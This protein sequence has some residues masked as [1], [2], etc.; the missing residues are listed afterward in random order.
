MKAKHV[1]LTMGLSLVMGLGVAA[2]MSA[3]REVK[4]ANAVAQTC[5]FDV[6][7]QANLMQGNERYATY[8]F[9]NTSN[10]WVSMTGV[11]GNIY[12]FSADPAT[13]DHIILCRMNKAAT[14]NKWENKWDQTGNL[15]FTTSTK[16]FRAT[17]QSSDG[18]FSAEAYT[19][20]YGLVGDK[21]G[22]TSD[23]D[24]VIDGV[25]ATLTKVMDA[26]DKVKVRANHA[27]TVS[28]GY[29]S[30][31]STSK[32][33]FT[34]DGENMQANE[35]GA[36]TFD[37]NFATGTLNVTF[38][39]ATVSV[40]IYKNDTATKYETQNVALGGLPEAPAYVY[41]ESFDG[42]WYTDAAMETECTGVTASTTKLYCK[43]TVAA[44]VTFTLDKTRATDKFA[45]TYLYTWFEGH[46]PKTAWPG[47][48]FTTSTF[49]VK[50]GS[51]FII[52]AGQGKEQTVDVTPST[53]ANDTLRILNSTDGEGHYNVKWASEVDS[54]KYSI[55]GGT[56][57]S[58]QEEDDEQFASLTTVEL[59]KGD[60]ITFTKNGAPYA[61]TPKDDDQFTNVYLNGDDELVA[62]RDCNEKFYLNVVTNKLWN[63][64]FPSGFY[65]L[66]DNNGWN[67][68]TG[69]AASQ[70]GESDTY[71]VENVPL[72]AGQGIKMTYVDSDAK[73]VTYYN[74]DASKVISSTGVAYSVDDTNHNLIATNGGTYNIY[75]NTTST[76]YSIEDTVAPTYKVSVNGVAK[77]LPTHEGTE[78][79]TA[80]LTLTAGQEIKVLRN[81]VVDTS[82]T[83]KQSRN[84]NVRSDGTVLVD[85]TNAHIYV[86]TS[87]KTIFVEGVPFGG[88]H[89]IRNDHELITMTHGSEY[90][91]YDQYYSDMVNFS[92]NDK[93]KFV[94]T[95]DQYD[96]H[97]T[98]IPGLPDEF[99]IGTINPG[100]NG[101]KFAVDGEYIKCITAIQTKVYLKLKYHQDEVYFGTVEQ[102]ITD[103]ITF[104]QNFC[105]AIEDVCED[106]ESAK[107]TEELATARTALENAWAAQVTAFNGLS[108]EA[109]NYLKS[110]A[111]HSVHELDEFFAKYDRVYTYRGIRF[112]WTLFNFLEVNYN[113]SAYINPI[114]INKT[115]S[116]VMVSIIASMVTLFASA[117]VVLFLFKKK[118]HN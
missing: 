52:N 51:K 24:M 110:Q 105:T 87:D 109:R 10:G 12:S 15:D 36:Y 88:Y 58:L 17:S 113:N 91:G 96:E 21:I 8:Y 75:Y 6:N 116:V 64:E 78:Y 22:W 84:N 67:V 47:D 56:E 9:N 1:F 79:S 57:I 104:G 85:A 25:H 76:Y 80:A 5:Y 28:Y 34:A 71:Y 60:V 74:A 37:L 59:H 106:V 30:L 97:E 100:D 39:D 63:G 7:G 44:D 101:P 14:E 65:L 29:N 16:Y 108:E 70:E 90:E 69:L 20:V 50:A 46:D 102:Y 26:G 2:G 23:I 86:D 43:T 55:N 99:S 27:W 95:N 77:E 61:V 3:N 92:V 103:A 115:N 68:K 35:S 33:L 4:A 107:T 13:Y 111:A 81:D 53:V 118:K 82:F 114:M 31:D 48:K 73:N 66:G 42:K 89:I 54:Y 32:A 49:T 83:L 93:I 38:S 11:G 72:A 98:R 41:G 19:P 112:G 18:V 117:G 40:D 94:N 62:A 45:D